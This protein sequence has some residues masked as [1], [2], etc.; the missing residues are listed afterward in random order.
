M[1]TNYRKYICRIQLASTYVLKKIRTEFEVDE[2]ISHFFLSGSII[3]SVLHLLF[4]LGPRELVKVTQEL[5]GWSVD[6]FS[7][8]CNKVWSWVEE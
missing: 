6:T 7:G 1:F 2:S 5:S 8:D 3:S 4:S